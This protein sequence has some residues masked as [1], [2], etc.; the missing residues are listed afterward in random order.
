MSLHKRINSTFLPKSINYSLQREKIPARVDVCVCVI[1]A[2]TGLSNEV[3]ILTTTKKIDPYTWGSPFA[4]HAMNRSWASLSWREFSFESDN[5]WA[6]A[7]RIHSHRTQAICF[8]NSSHWWLSKWTL[9]LPDRNPVGYSAEGRSANHRSNSVYFL[10][11]CQNVSGCWSLSLKI[12]IRKFNDWGGGR[13]RNNFS[14]RREYL[15]F[16][17]FLLKIVIFFSLWRKYRNFLIAHSK[18]YIYI[19]YNILWIAK[20]TGNRSRNTKISRPNNK[21][22]Q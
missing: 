16:V 20:Q 9:H 14:L 19:F 21:K 7:L 11:Y 3:Y 13:G 17:Y 8:G 22:T 12:L 10:Y 1:W 4:C 18:I 2:Q 15:K 5:R 6:A